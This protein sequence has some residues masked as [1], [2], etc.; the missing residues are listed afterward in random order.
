MKQTAL[1]E[2]NVL[3][4][5]SEKSK[6]LEETYI[7]E[8]KC[9]KIKFALFFIIFF[10]LLFFFWYYVGCFCAVYENTQSQLLDDTLISFFIS[11]LYPLFIYLIPGCFRIPALKDIKQDS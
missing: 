1:S 3:K 4:I 11:L 6:K 2:S 5:K 9:I 7:S 8:V 10:I